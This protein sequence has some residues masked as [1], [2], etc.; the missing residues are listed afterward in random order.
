MARVAGIAY[1]R[2]NGRQLP[3]KG[4]FMVS[5]SSFERSK[6]VGQDYVHGTAIN[7]RAPF[8]EGDITLIRDLSIE[9]LDAIE[10][11]TVTA[12]LANG[13]GYVLRNADCKSAHELNTK[14]GQVRVRFEGDSCDEI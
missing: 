9:D 14:D 5:P 4:S 13:R 10:G 2:V 6:V 7:P 1:I 12:E 8:I 11:A 3:L